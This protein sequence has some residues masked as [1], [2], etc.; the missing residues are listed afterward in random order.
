VHQFPENASKS[1]RSKEQ[2]ISVVNADLVYCKNKGLEGHRMGPIIENKR[3]YMYSIFQLWW[4]V[5]MEGDA[6]RCRSLGVAVSSLP[7][8]E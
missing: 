1:N 2:Y 4:E 8:D 7:N 5:L 3:A 6:Q